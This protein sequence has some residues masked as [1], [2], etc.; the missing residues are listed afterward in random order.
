MM[1]IGI[2]KRDRQTINVTYYISSLIQYLK[3]N[4]KWWPDS[5]KKLSVLSMYTVYEQNMI[6]A[7]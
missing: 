7:M 6:F 1:T 5:T 3:N 4:W 2:N